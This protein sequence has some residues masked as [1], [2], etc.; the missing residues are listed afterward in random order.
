[1]DLDGGTPADWILQAVPDGLWVLDDDGITTWANQRF[2]D[3]L[4]LAEDEVV[5]FPAVEALDAEGRVQFL[6]HLDRLRTTRD[7]GADLECLLVRRDGTELWALVSH[8]PLLDG[9][10]EHRGWLHRVRDHSGSGPSSRRS[11]A[12]SAS[13]PRPS[14]SRTSAAGSALLSEDVL[15][16]SD[17]LYR[18]LGV[19]PGDARADP[20]LLHGAAPPGRPRSRPRGVR[21]DG[22]R[23]GAGRRRR[24]SRPPGRR[25]DTLGADPGSS[26]VRRRGASSSGSAAPCRTSPRPRRPSRGSPSSARWPAPP[27][28]RRTLAGGAARLRHD[29]AALHAVAGGGGV[30]ARPGETRR[31]RPL[32]HGLARLRGGRPAFARAIAEEVAA[33]RAAF[34]RIAGRTASTRRRRGPGRRPARLRDRLRHP[35]RAAEP[36]AYDLAIFDQM[37]DLLAERRRAGGGR[38]RSSPPPAT[39]RCSASRAKSE[40][41]ATMSHEIRTPLNGVIGLSELLRPHRALAR[42]SAGSPRASTRRAAR[43][44]PWSTTSSTSPRS[45]PAGSTS[46]RSTSTRGPV[47]EQSVGLVADRGAREGPRAGR[48]ERGQP[49]RRWCAA[50]PCAS[51]R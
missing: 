47:V 42:T 37:L 12:A 24:P 51:A 7:A 27:T 44:S 19:D 6:D 14:R 16:W 38:P 18:V 22:P 5:G 49:A 50:T 34:Q 10:G 48:L 3:L 31:A 2:A 8:V 28:R 40:F 36:R 17:E 33:D 20:G 26:R 1:M 9:A 35:V 13:S 15:H 4:G 39:R 29:R 32:R 41:L 11:S 30:G 25:G 23:R 45:R 46:R 21:R 43:C